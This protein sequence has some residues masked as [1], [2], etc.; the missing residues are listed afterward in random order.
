[1]SLTCRWKTSADG[2]SCCFSGCEA[3][4]GAGDLIVFFGVKCCCMVENPGLWIF[5]EDFLDDGVD[6]GNPD[7]PGME[8]LPRCWLG[9][10]P[11]C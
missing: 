8:L 7:A 10:G 6:D 11:T 1:M 9:D 4:E 3:I 5:I 2:I